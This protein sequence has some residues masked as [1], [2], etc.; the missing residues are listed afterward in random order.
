MRPVSVLD[1]LEKNDLK[2]DRDP[3][4]FPRDKVFEEFLS[5]VSNKELV[6]VFRFLVL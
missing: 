4:F 5:S 2:L 3:I 1:D 6:L